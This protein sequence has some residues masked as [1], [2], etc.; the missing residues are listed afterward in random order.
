MTPTAGVRVTLVDGDHH[1][2]YPGSALRRLERDLG[3]WGMFQTQPIHAVCV[4]VWAGLLHEDPNLTLD[5]ASDLIDFGRMEE[6][7]NAVTE[8]LKQS[9]LA[10]E[11]KKPGKPRPS[12]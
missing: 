3:G 12:R 5:A 7:G 4:A 1:L 2:R 6:V 10:V 8:A 9:G 11:D